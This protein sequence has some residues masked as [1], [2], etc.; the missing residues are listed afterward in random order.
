VAQWFLGLLLLVAIMV[1][2]AWYWADSARALW[3]TVSVLVVTCPCALALA[4]PIALT[5]AAGASARDGLL[6]TRGHA[7]ETLAR[8]THFIFDKTGTLTTGQMR[9]LA[10]QVVRDG[11]T[12]EEALNVAAVLETASAHPLA[13]A[14]RTSAEETRGDTAVSLLARHVVAQVAG[15]EGEVDGRVLRIGRPD[16]ARALSAGAVPDDHDRLPSDWQG[17]SDT[18]VALADAS[19]VLAYFRV[20]DKSRPGARAL[21]TALKAAGCRTLLMSGDTEAVARR[22]AAHLGLDEA[23]GG[24]TPEDKQAAARRLQQSGAIVA[25]MGDGVN[26][27]P[28]LA[29]AEVSIALGSGAQLARTQ[30]DLIL[31]SDNL[32]SITRGVARSRQTL[33][34]I[35]QNLIW[36]FVYNLLALPLAIAGHVQPWAAGIGMSASSLLVVLN[37]LRLQRPPRPLA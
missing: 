3:I 23:M 28:V 24:M 32:D 33:A 29:Q 8:A 4:T 14:I 34:I 2:V 13:V 6:I 18:V 27:A 17:A 19:G 11:M 20:G 37:A 1:A 16:F 35:R 9:V 31:L 21:V 15:L 26:D 5:V 30:A 36:A 12:R 10:I 22:M 7:L 25:M